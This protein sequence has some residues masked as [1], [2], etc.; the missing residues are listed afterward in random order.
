[1]NVSF[2]NWKRYIEGS[3]F[4]KILLFTLLLVAFRYLVGIFIYYSFPMTYREDYRLK[5]I[6]IPGN[7]MNYEDVVIDPVKIFYRWDTEYYM[8]IATHGYIHANYRPGFFNWAFYPLYPMIVAVI[9]RLLSIT[10]I[11]QVYILG[12][13]ISNA[14]FLFALYVWVKLMRVLGFNKQEVVATLALFISFPAN[15]FFNLT[16]T[17]SLYLFLSVGLFYLLVKKKL[18][19]SVWAI[20]L[21]LVT[22]VTALL[23]VVPLL[24]STYCEWYRE[25]NAIVGFVLHVVASF[26]VIF[27][28]LLMFFAYMKVVTGDAFTPF[29]IQA[30]W[31]NSLPIPFI[32]FAAYAYL[33]GLRIYLPSVLSVA[34]LL[35]YVWTSWALIKKLLGKKNALPNWNIYFSLAIYSVLLVLLATS[36]SSLNSIFRYLSVNF[37]FPMLLVKLYHFTTSS[38]WVWV[39]VSIGL[40]FQVLFFAYYILNVPIY[41]F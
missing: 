18:V 25:K 41:G 22:R 30:V 19:F 39:L 12:L 11:Q 35:A 13:V 28:P 27:T 14:F 40:V 10:S 4:L 37:A 6:I 36:V 23:L 31:G 8:D 7:V 9:A 15:Y 3:L 21:A 38:T 24:I 32:A 2:K 17:E 20:A 34:I 33:Y 29:K 5:P 16:Y 1:M 26:I